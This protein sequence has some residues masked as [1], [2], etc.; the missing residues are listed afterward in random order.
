MTEFIREGHF[1]RH[2]RSMRTL[3]M[4]RRVAVHDAIRKYLG[5][6]LQVI[7]TE[8]GMQ[9]AGLLPQG[10]DDVAVSRKAAAK[11]VSVR[12]LTPCY[13]EPPQRGGLILGY[14]GANLVQID[15]GVRRLAECF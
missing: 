10:V 3:Y 12:P 9:L 4:E 8:A 1:A 15:E 14:G 13:I 5:E 2:I 6:R 11:G 7:G